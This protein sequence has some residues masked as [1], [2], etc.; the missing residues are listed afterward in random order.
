MPSADRAA[1][2]ATGIT[3][4]LNEPKGDERNT[5]LEKL[6]DELDAIPAATFDQKFG[7]HSRLLGYYRGDDI[8]AGIIKHATWMAGAARSFAC[9]TEGV[10]LA[11]TCRRRSTWRKRSPARA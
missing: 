10:R 3:V 8:D 9:A 7:A 2:I 5:R 1:A 4:I 11:V 6:I